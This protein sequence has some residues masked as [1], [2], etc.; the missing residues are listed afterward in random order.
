MKEMWE[1]S[2]LQC[3]AS[4]GGKAYLKQIYAEIGKFVSLTKE[5]WKVEYGRPAYQHQVRSHIA[6]LNQSGHLIKIL[7]GL[8]SLT[9]KGQERLK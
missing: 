2:I 6:N 3:I 8:Y 9:E 4:L 5:H 7:R 1:Y